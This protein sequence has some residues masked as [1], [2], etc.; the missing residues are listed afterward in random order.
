MVEVLFWDN[1]KG[2]ASKVVL[3]RVLSEGTDC[4]CLL[5]DTVKTVSV[6]TKW[7][8]LSDKGRGGFLE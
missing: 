1:V 2:L 6:S 7:L 5:V 3:M 4:K 8:S